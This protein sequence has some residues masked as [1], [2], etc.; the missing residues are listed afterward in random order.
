MYYATQEY[1]DLTIYGSSGGREITF[2]EKDLD[3]YAYLKYTDKVEHN[4]G[5]LFAGTY[6]WDC[7]E[8]VEDFIANENRTDL[9]SGGIFD[10]TYG[11]ALTDEALTALQGKQ[12]VLR[13]VNTSIVESGIPEVQLDVRGTFVD[14][15]SILRLKFETDGI[16]YNLGVID[17]KQTGSDTPSNEDKFDVD[18]SDEL[19]ELLAQL[20]EFLAKFKKIVQIV[21]LIVLLALLSP[22]LLSVVRCIFWIVS[23]PFKLI[24]SIF[25]KL[26]SSNH[27]RE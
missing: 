7:I 14:N 26:K 22:I 15:V 9:Y 2:G 4:G 18:F 1:R 23:L 19:K 16:T 17:N 11:S 24:G 12:W 3:G 6:T 20:K 27:K 8:T 13:F 5:G 10:V 25:K 21:F